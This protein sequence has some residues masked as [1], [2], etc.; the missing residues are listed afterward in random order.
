MVPESGF[1]SFKSDLDWALSMGP[2]LHCLH[3]WP[4]DPYPSTS[5]FLEGSRPE[6]CGVRTPSDWAP[7]PFGET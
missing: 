6:L 1:W 3:G 2:V 4:L 7:T 5:D